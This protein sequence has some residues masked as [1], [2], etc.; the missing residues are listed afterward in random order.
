MIFVSLWD[1]RLSAN[2]S[3]TVT[4]IFRVIS[5]LNFLL[6]FAMMFHVLF[7]YVK[8][9]Y[10]LVIDSAG[11]H[12]HSGSMTAKLTEWS[13]ITRYKVTNFAGIRFLIVYVKY[14]EEMIKSAKFINKLAMYL[15][16]R[17][18]KTPVVILLLFLDYNFDNL[19]I[20]LAKVKRQ[21][22]KI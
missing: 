11:I 8:S 2:Q 5:S 6:F 10:G 14:P 12:D 20:D 19:T 17:F 15:N 3:E 21:A 18:Y 9:H 7:Y 4:L 22:G 16:Y 13:E 1:W